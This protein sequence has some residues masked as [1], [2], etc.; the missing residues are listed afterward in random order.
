[1]I[2]CRGV[3]WEE[4]PRKRWYPLEAGDF[5]KLSDCLLEVEQGQI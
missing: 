2:R 1:M 5:I 4:L 3:P